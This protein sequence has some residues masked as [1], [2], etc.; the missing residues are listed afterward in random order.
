MSTT[1]KSDIQ[2]Y[3]HQESRRDSLLK[4]VARSLLS[5]HIPVGTINRRLFGFGYQTHCMLRA[6]TG[7][8]L[9]FLWF[10]P[11]FRSQC[12]TVGSRF[13]MEQLPY[14]V[15]RGKI[16]IGDGVRFSGKPSMTFSSRYSAEPILQIGDGSFLGHNCGLTI[17]RSIHIGRNCLVA[18]NVRISDFD[19]HPLDADLRRRGEPAAAEDVQPVSIGNDVWIGHGAIILKGVR[20]GDRAVIGARA[21]VTGDVPADAVVAGNPARIVKQLNGP[22]SISD[23]LKD[24]N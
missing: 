5:Y 6:V 14:I 9:R 3:R 1:T 15:G 24:A 19:G 4:Q 10:E 7:W 18:G 22:T 12:K 21:V 23:H 11:L 8:S 16:L 17:G 13:Q 20:I 2:G